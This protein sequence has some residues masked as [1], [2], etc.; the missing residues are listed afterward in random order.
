MVPDFAKG[1]CIGNWLTILNVL[2]PQSQSLSHYDSPHCLNDAEDGLESQCS[3]IWILPP[4]QRVLW[5]MAIFE[6]RPFSLGF[7]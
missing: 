4:Q 7:R 2:D 3:Q 5:A 6:T 1:L